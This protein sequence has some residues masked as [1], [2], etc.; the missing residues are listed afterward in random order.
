MDAAVLH[1]YGTP[2][3]GTFDDPIKRIGTEIVDVTAAAYQRMAELAASEKLIVPVE[4]MPLQQ[5]EQAWE[6]QRA[7]TR[8]RLVLIP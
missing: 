1:A 4:R 7:G 6:H 3:F 8:P 5:V 2:Q